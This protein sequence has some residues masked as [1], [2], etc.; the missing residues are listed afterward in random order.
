MK[1]TSSLLIVS[2]IFASFIFIFNSGQITASAATPVQSPRGLTP[3]SLPP[4]PAVD[5]AYLYSYSET[6]SSTF[7]NDITTFTAQFRSRTRPLN[8]LVDIE[9]FDQTGKQL[10]QKNWDN[11][12]LTTSSSTNYSLTSPRNLSPGVYTWK[13]A[14]FTPGWKEKI[15]WYDSVTTFAVLGTTTN[16]LPSAYIG[17]LWQKDSLLTEGRAQYLVAYFDTP[18]D[19]TGTNIQVDLFD[20]HNN[21]V[22][23]KSWDEVYLGKDYH[24]S[25]SVTSPSLSSGEYHWGIAL[26]STGRKQLISWIDNL[27]PFEVA[28]STEDLTTK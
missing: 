16:S 6:A 11:V 15:N 12:T 14:V 10:L 8:A 17:G 25:K 5:S 22:F 28:S 23:E 19:S 1:K 2:S 3:A 20:A 4:E 9:L 18:A 13:A 26:F 7:P 24:S 27:A 21:I